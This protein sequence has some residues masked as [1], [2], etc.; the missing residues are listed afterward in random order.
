MKVI[1]GSVLAVLI[2]AVLGF[3]GALLSVFADGLISERLIVIA[4]V[5]L[6]YFTVGGIFGFFLKSCSWKTGLLIGAPAVILLGLYSR[7]GFN[8]YYTVYMLLIL[9]LSCIG[10]W[11]GS[12]ISTRLKK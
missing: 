4:V 10:T 12:R 7:T 11:T 2:G 8:A 6:V 9:F 5:L 1:I 3:Y